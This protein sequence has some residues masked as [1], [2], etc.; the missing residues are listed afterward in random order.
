MRFKKLASIIKLP[1]NLIMKTEQ[2][3]WDENKGWVSESIKADLKDAQ[4]V[5][6]FWF[7]KA[8]AEQE[9]FR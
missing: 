8:Y 2:R 1:S 5:F 4:L 9:P 7:Y 3:H 6:C